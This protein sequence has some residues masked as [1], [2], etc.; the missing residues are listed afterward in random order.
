MDEH[1]IPVYPFP[2]DDADEFVLDAYVPHRRTK[3]N[4]MP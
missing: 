2:E 4:D 3:P 1:Y